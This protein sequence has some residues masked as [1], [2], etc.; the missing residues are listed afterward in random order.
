LWHIN[1]RLFAQAG[2]MR[3]GRPILPGSA[4][5][6]VDHARQFRAATGKPYLIQSQVADPA[7]HVRNL[8]TYLLTQQAVIFPDPLHVRLRTPEAQR[9]V[10]F[11]RLLNRERLTTLDQDNPAAIASFLN[12]EGGVFP[13]GTWMIGGFDQE[14]RTAGRPL[15]QSYA[16]F[17]YPRLFG[18][19]DAAFVDGHSWVMPRRERTPVQRRAL[20][21]LLRFM[22]EHD[23]DWSRTGHL[24]AFRA[25]VASPQFQALPHRRDIAPLATIGSPLPGFVQ[26]QGA[27]EGL[28]GE[29]VAAAVSGQEPVDHAL[30]DAERRVN[31]LLAQTL[32]RAER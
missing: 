21:R 2:L 10:E 4:E 25:V 24:P 23:F 22:A 13:T 31:E 19:R 12:G 32:S 7:T 28:I 8:Y 9:V 3:N 30:A 5:E 6:L 15:Y 17:P 26:R 16:V 29:E 18:Q 20:A 27:I 1:T 14:A 11:F